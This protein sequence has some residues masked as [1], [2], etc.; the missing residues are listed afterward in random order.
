M[1]KEFQNHSPIC[2]AAETTLHANVNGATP[3][4]T[5]EEQSETL[6]AREGFASRQYCGPNNRDEAKRL[7]RPPSGI[8][9]VDSRS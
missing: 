6:S 3:I 9:Y 4:G 8:E 2:G 7:E 1:P 5:A